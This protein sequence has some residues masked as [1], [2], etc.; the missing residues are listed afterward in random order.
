M[1]ELKPEKHAGA[2][3]EML[4]RAKELEPKI[5]KRDY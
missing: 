1:R 4:N 3:L 5:F 2:K